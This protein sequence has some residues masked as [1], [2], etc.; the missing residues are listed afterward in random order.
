M[1][2]FRE[3][4]SLTTPTRQTIVPSYEPDTGVNT[5]EKD[6]VSTFEQIVL[7]VTKEFTQAEKNKLTELIGIPSGGTDGQVVT[8][9]SN[10]PN[11]VTWGEGG[12]G[13]GAPASGPEGS[14]Q[15]SDGT[16]GF[17]DLV[18]LKV[19]GNTLVTENFVVNG[20]IQH[21]LFCSEHQDWYYDKKLYELVI[22]ALP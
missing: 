1:K 2:R 10:A 22:K 7:T 15:L 19:I 20:N 9:D 6:T 12:S 21:I 11:G 3:K 16:G 13:G 14:V 17:T 5:E 8:K 4:D 18:D